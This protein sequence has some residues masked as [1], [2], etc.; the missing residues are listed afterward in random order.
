[1][2]A[3]CRELRIPLWEL[4]LDRLL[5]STLRALVRGQ[6]QSVVRPSLDGRRMHAVFDGR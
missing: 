6:A 4:Q 2:R 3:G 5:K 1:M